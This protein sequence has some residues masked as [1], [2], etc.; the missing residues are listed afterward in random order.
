M[1]DGDLATQAD[2]DAHREERS[3]RQR[4]RH[5]PVDPLPTRFLS[6]L[7]S[8]FCSTVDGMPLCLF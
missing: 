4:L 8:F 2:V 3:K 7:S 5:S 1:H 6:A